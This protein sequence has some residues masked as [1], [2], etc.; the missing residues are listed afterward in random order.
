MLKQGLNIINKR[1]IL[2]KYFINQFVCLFVY[3]LQ[4]VCRIRPPPAENNDQSQVAKR[5]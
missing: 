4:Q 3:L 2:Q 1:E 5:M